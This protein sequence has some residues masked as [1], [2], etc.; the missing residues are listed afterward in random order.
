VL[1]RED[2]ELLTRI[3]PGTPMG[4][5]FRQYWLPVLMSSELPEQDGPP[6]RVRILGEDLVAFRDTSGRVGLLAH[7]C[8]HRGASLFFGRNEQDGLRC[9]YH[10]WKYDVD[11]HCVEM[12]NEPLES[13]FRDK[14]RHRAYPCR[15]MNGAIWAYLGPRQDPPPLPDLE[16]LRVPEEQVSVGKTLRE[17]NW[18][19]ALEGD[20]DN[21]HVPFLHSQLDFRAE[22]GSATRFYGR[23]MHLEVADTEYGAMYGVR[24]DG[25]AGEYNWRIIQFLFPSFSMITIGTPRERGVVP[26]HMWVP[27]DDTHTMQWGIKWHPTQALP[28][29]VSAQTPSDYVPDGSGWLDQ[30]QPTANRT[31]DYMIDREV[32]R[33]VSFSGVPSIPLQD[34]MATESMGPV[35]DRARE[36]LGT[37]DAMIIR[38]RRR[39]IAA[40]KALREEGVPPPGVDRPELYRVRSAIVNLPRDANW[41]EATRATVKATT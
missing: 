26:S 20:I 13:N 17:C 18:M 22:D 19:Q 31:N 7:N 10:G 28:D 39:L 21:A 11:G 29:G 37:T 27:M 30:W 1:T 4:D 5:L 40:A 35:V 25:E 3:G 24:R 41:V 33:T 9:V 14:V 16:W 36:H 8:S 38:V 2:S 15:E 23:P 6:K 12:P 32:Q 34:K